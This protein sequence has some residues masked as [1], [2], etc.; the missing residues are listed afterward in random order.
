MT[1]S[2]PLWRPVSTPMQMPL[3]V[4]ITAVAIAIVNIPLRLRAKRLAI[5]GGMMSSDPMSRTPRYR[6]PR[7]MVKAKASKK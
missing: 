3:T 4:E 2:G 5:A 6:N 1:M 7:P